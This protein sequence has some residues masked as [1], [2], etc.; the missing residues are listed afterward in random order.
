MGLVFCLGTFLVGMKE[1]Y[2]QNISVKQQLE[3]R[4]QRWGF[5]WGRTVGWISVPK[6]IRKKKLSWNPEAKHYNKRQ[7]VQDQAIFSPIKSVI[8]VF[9]IYLMREMISLPTRD[10]EVTAVTPAIKLSQ[11]GAE[12]H[13]PPAF[14]SHR[15]V[16]RCCVTG[17]C[18][19]A[20]PATCL[21]LKDRRLSRGLCTTA[22]WQAACWHLPAA[23]CHVFPL[24][25][26]SFSLSKVWF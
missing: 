26:I 13:W 16:M 20:D 6:I 18:C 9:L 21:P 1:E 11:E 3:K 14:P 15:M 12:Q 24:F 10:H 22:S 8:T 25:S 4:V 5:S 19:S 7:T 17:M 2:S 23:R